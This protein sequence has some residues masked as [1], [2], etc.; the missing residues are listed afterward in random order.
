MNERHKVHNSAGHDVDKKVG[1]GREEGEGGKDQM[2]EGE[3]VW[4]TKRRGVF[5]KR[6]RETLN[7]CL[8]VCACLCW[9]D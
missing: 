9:C 7:L 3:G 5:D 2:R 1:K 4:V 6:E 8:C